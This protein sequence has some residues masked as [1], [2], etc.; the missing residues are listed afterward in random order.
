MG[1]VDWSSGRDIL[2]RR[3][4]VEMGIEVGAGRGVASFGWETQGWL[5]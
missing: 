4:G 1:L 5:G 2:V 3:V